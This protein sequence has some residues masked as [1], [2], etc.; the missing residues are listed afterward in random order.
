[1]TR[2]E[3]VKVLAILKAAYPASYKGMNKQ[4]ANGVITVWSTQFAK[5]PAEV[6]LIA[7]QKLIA[8]SNFPPTIAEVKSKL[9]GLYWETWGDTRQHEQG[10]LPM[11]E[12]TLRRAKI[13]MNVCSEYNSR[14]TQEPTL[15]E[16]I[17]GVQN[18]ITSGE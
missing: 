5:I 13:V 2:D 17:G 3:T 16:L 10:T 7:V 15:S 12:T 11:D 8:T 4:E 9:R 18:Y 1:M 6:I 14:A